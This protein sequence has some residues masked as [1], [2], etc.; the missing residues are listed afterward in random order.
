MINS[1]QFLRGV[2]ALMVL[3]F[4]A[5][6]MVYEKIGYQVAFTNT[7]A[8]GVDLFFVI[9]GFVIYLVF[10]KDIYSAPMFFAKRIVRV[11]PP[12][13]LYT[14]ITLAIL[15]LMPNAFKTKTFDLG[16]VVSSYLFLLSQQP[17]GGVGTLLGV[18]WTIAFEMYFYLLFFIAMIAAPKKPL[19]FF[20]SFI[21]IGAMA[22]TFIPERAVPPF[23]LVA[24][25]ALPLEFLGGCLVARAYLNGARIPGIMAVPLIALGFAVMIYGGIAERIAY[26]RDPW[27]VLFW[28]V[29]ALLIVSSL[30]SID[31][32]KPIR[33]PKYTL[34]LG[35]ASYSLYLSHQF[36]LAAI[37]KSASVL[38]LKQVVSSEI[39]V[40][41]SMTLAIG[42]ALLS[43]YFFERP[44]TNVLNRALEGNHAPKTA[45][46]A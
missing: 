27:R 10:A 12:Y 34:I 20:A 30:V 23:T 35:G 33:F 13:W 22:S 37:G 2:A 17:V 46:S 14:T 11:G 41:F 31:A 39:L 44:V 25:S 3:F 5:Q 16:E 6:T 24:L 21:V 38:R 36:V 1:I 4:H 19:T 40:I 42:V 8:A 28:G 7:G 29:P 15:L 45:V 26:D 9:S 18:G 32:Q 43:Y